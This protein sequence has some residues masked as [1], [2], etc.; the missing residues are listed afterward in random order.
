MK[1]KK[2]NKSDIGTGRLRQKAEEAIRN[3]TSSNAV[4]LDTGDIMKLLHELQVHQVE[5]EM[6]NEELRLAGINAEKESEKYTTLFDFAPSGYFSLGRDGTISELNLSGALMLGKER[7]NLVKRNFMHFVTGDTQ[8]IFNDFILKIFETNSKQNCEVRLIVLGNPSRYIYIEGKVSP[9]VQKCILTAVDITERKQAEKALLDEEAMIKAITNA[10]QDAILMIDPA[11]N[12][13]FANPAV[14]RIFGYTI[15]EILGKNLHFLLTPQHYHRSHQESFNRF[16]ATGEGRKLGKIEELMA[17]HKDGHEIIVELSLSAIERTDGRYAAGIIRDITERK[18]TEDALHKSRKEFQSYFDAGS[19]GLS[20][21]A[22]DESWIE[23]NQR[24][25]QI[26]GYAKE[27]LTC[28][29]WAELSHPDDIKANLELFQQALEGKID[30]Y[31]LDKRFFRKD[32]SIVYVAL[33]VVCQ[34]NDDGSVHHFLSSY[35]DITERRLAAEELKQSEERYRQILNSV[36]EIIYS[37]STENDPLHQVVEFVSGRS[38]QILGY[39]PDE[40]ISNPSLWFSI[41]HPDDIQPLTEV[42][43]QSFLTKQN[44]PRTYRMKHKLTGEYIW[45]EDHPQF[46]FDKN[47]DISGVFGSASN[48]S[49]RIRTEEALRESEIIYRNLIDKMPDGVYKSTH[50]G[51][52]IEVNPAMVS[53]LGYDSKEQLLAIDIKTELYFDPAERD[54]LTL[55]ELREELGIFRLRKKD[56]SE[57]WVEDHGWYTSA[58]TGETLY[59]EGVIRDVTGRIQAENALHESELVYR[60]LID[61]MPDG[62]YKTTHEGKFVEVNPAM[63]QMLGYDNKEELMS[64]DIKTQL[65]FDPVDRESLVLEQQLNEMGV[66]RLRKK[67]GSEIWVEDHGWYSP[68]ENGETLF[69][70][71]VMRDI[72]DRKNAEEALMESQ[73]LFQNITMVSPSGIFRST[74]DGYTTYVNP[75]WSELSGLSFDEA[76]GYGWLNAVHPDD[77]NRLS[78]NWSQDVIL[79]KPSTAEYRFLKPDGSIVFV[80]GYAVPETKD[81]ILTG[82]IGTITDITERKQAEEEVISLNATLEQRVI[83]RTAQLE[84]ANK[85]L[86]AFSYSISHDLRTPLRALDGFAN[87]LLEDYSKVLDDEGKRMLRVIIDN[88]NKMGFLIDDLLAFSR[89]SRYKLKVATIDMKAM[90]NSVYHEL[91]TPAEKESIDFRLQN[92]P[93]AFG[94]PSMIRQVWLNLI[95]N[96]IKYTSKKQNRII[97][98]LSLTQETE[99]I[100]IVKDNGSGFNMDYYNK[101]F[102]VFQR[103]HT[104]KDFEGTGIGLA[105]V[106]RIVLRHKGRVWAEGVVGEGATFSFT[107]GNKS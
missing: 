104:I 43:Q 37:L 41:I 15:D 48:I 97:E 31:E 20:V 13:S 91:A 17:I 59:H 36:D 66:Y 65:Y 101:L 106:N 107:I 86:E 34:R 24:L 51:R 30:K 61:R 8:T 90:A 82:F 98:V 88:A 18:L 80:I 64:I 39:A 74:V 3:N 57:I 26:L 45:I 21:T 102:G 58:E 79:K 6:Q 55:D 9:D 84:A 94:D 76:I 33:S 27:E 10:A 96:A 38:V 52:F 62:V 78:E 7:S 47:G 23:F 75:R 1:M 28:L 49:E 44:L 22:S 35:N 100:Y 85:E 93:D 69:H 60:N 4:N 105:I 12:I 83:H 11:G 103:L 40:F 73:L 72:T 42:T 67:D 87:F 89:L 95:S 68:D 19:I 14:E 5:L 71:G 54:S 29:S 32:G 81:N 63:V 25:C 16:I 77:R 2:A 70:E 92:I 46:L 56:G 53:M 50:D 99:T